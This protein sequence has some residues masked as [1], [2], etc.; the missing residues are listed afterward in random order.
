MGQQIAMVCLNPFRSVVFQPQIAEVM[1]SSS[2][3]AHPK[4]S[5]A[6]RSVG[7]LLV[8]RGH[9][10]QL[11]RPALAA[12]SLVSRSWATTAM[13][14][15][16][17]KLCLQWF[18][19]RR[20]VA[21]N[22][23]GNPTTPSDRPSDRPDYEDSEFDSEVHDDDDAVRELLL[24]RERHRHG[25]F[26][27]LPDDIPPLVARCS[28]RPPAD[29]FN[30]LAHVRV[31]KAFVAPRKE[32]LDVVHAL[33]SAGASLTHL[34]LANLSITTE[35]LRT[36]EPLVT[37]LRF[38]DLGYHVYV[39]IPDSLQIGSF[40]SGLKALSLFCVMEDA[41]VSLVNSNVKTLEVFSGSKD[42]AGEVLPHLAERKLKH[43]SLSLIDSDHPSLIEAV[44]HG[45]GELLVTLKLEL[46]LNESFPLDII[47]EATPNL[48]ALHIIDKSLRKDLS[49]PVPTRC[50]PITTLS[51]WSNFY[52]TPVALV[53]RLAL[54]LENLQLTPV[55]SSEHGAG[56]L[57]LKE[58]LALA[59]L[60][61]F[62]KLRRFG[63]Y[64]PAVYKEVDSRVLADL[65]DA[66]PHVEV[67]QI[68]PP[69]GSLLPLARLRALRS[70]EIPYS[71]GTGIAADA[72]GLVV[73]ARAARDAGTPPLE[74]VLI[75]TTQY[76]HALLDALRRAGEETGGVVRAALP[77]GFTPRL[78]VFKP[79]ELLEYAV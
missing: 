23:V 58:S 8:Q 45:C 62:P 49:L 54:T 35:L 53:A 13:S 10:R 26:E 46:Q 25:F 30:P 78:E 50:P 14:V 16:Y 72:A 33:A 79:A 20:G 47:L 15:L 73:A 2:H 36:L 64:Q 31:L 66:C 71:D 37:G 44:S 76:Q 61:T 39:R 55:T 24:R 60:A 7:D 69:V 4:P 17:A 65:A 27:P 57:A 32:L 21:G 75:Y 29:P 63:F 40:F 42:H 67:L 6:A 1:S 51:V 5:S 41:A 56:T 43:L 19:R 11:P 9:L 77:D 70:L 52:R 28:A 48:Q 22:A 38:L 59:G 12:A 34:Y 3:N 18:S 68:P 74:R